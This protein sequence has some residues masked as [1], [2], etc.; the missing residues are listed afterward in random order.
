MCAFS[1]INSNSSQ[2]YMLPL[3]NLSSLSTNSLSTILNNNPNNKDKSPGITTSTNSIYSYSGDEY[4]QCRRIR[5]TA[6]ATQQKQNPNQYLSHQDHSHSTPRTPNERSRPRLS[7]FWRTVRLLQ[8]GVNHRRQTG[9]YVQQINSPDRN[10]RRTTTGISLQTTGEDENTLHRVNLEVAQ[11]VY[12]ELPATIPGVTQPMFISVSNNDQDDDQDITPVT[13][14]TL[15]N[16]IFEYF[17]HSH[18]FLF[19]LVHIAAKLP[20]HEDVVRVLIGEHTSMTSL[21]NSNGQIPLLCAI[22]AGS[23]LTGKYL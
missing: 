5:N 12:N 8:I 6:I 2:L 9:Q 10:E 23:T 7:R 16:F 4:R 3:S 17:F 19:F 1:S 22:Q 11:P 18:L 13:G 20:G 14:Q 21:A 15:C